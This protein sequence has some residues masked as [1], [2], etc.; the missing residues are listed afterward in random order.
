L[1]ILTTNPET[2]EIACASG[3]RSKSKIILAKFHIVVSHLVQLIDLD[4]D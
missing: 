1:K 2:L 4:A 3:V